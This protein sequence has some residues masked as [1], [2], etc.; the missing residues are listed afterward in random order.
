MS[1]EGRSPAGPAEREERLKDLVRQLAEIERRIQAET[2]GGIDAI[3][4]PSSAS[5][6]LLRA[7]QEALVESESR[8][9]RLAVLTS[10]LVFELAADGTIRFA[11][12][13]LLPVTGYRLDE[14]QGRNWW[15][16]F[17][18]GEARGEADAFVA[19]LGEGDVAG[20]E[21]A[22]HVRDGSRR[23]LEVTTANR[24]GVDGALETIIA[25]GVDVTNRRRAE[26]EREQLL[27]RATAAREQAEEASRAKD[28]FLA[29]VSH[30]LRTP[31]HAM[32]GW[33]RLLRSTRLDP[34]TFDRG[35]A[36]VE[37]NVQSQAH[38][39][40]DLL[41]L[42]RVT[43][44]KLRLD[45]HPVLVEP[46]IEAAVDSIRPTA[47]AKGI[48]LVSTVDPETNHVSADP[49]RL[50][51]VVW[52]LLSNAIKFTPK[53]GRVVVRV[54][55]VESSVEISVADNGQGISPDF[56]PHVFERFR[57]ADGAITRKFGGLGLGLAIVRHIVE[58]H[59]GTV[60]A[61]SEG[62]GRGATFTVRLPVAAVTRGSARAARRRAEAMSVP[63]DCP[64]S[65][66]GVRVLVVDDEPDTRDMITV[67]LEEC[68][69]EVLAV[70]TTAEALAAIDEWQP[71]LMVSDIGMPNEDGY[72]LIR[73]VRQRAAETG[74]SL[75]AIALTAYA[76]AEDRLKALS[77][78]FEMHVAKPVEPAELVMVIDRLIRL[79]QPGKG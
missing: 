11:N 10:A 71:N 36:T 20:H 55:R 7:A 13:A 35:L 69:A 49:A 30:E 65:L 1:Q 57:Q 67:V 8:Y 32:L 70:S 3:V 4:D 26:A 18:P 79:T 60:R 61:E 76:G 62:L 51:Q 77:A 27:A 5:V 6:I 40:D 25:M 39:I 43:S 54:R 23:L 64:P 74:R 17:F 63:F 12:D 68:Q 48:D 29:V 50:Q 31:L 33:M 66:E 44:G 21:L 53:N 73:K 47:E 19:R 45:M 58:L 34:A 52:N 14:V 37:R 28:E 22:I 72:Q 2:A 56:L 24:Y 9:R 38:L 41:D 78:G 42:S 15:D 75:P 46:I 59:G 16:L